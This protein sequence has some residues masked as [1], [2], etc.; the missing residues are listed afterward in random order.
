MPLDVSIISNMA[1]DDA[2]TNDDTSTVGEPS[3]AT[4]GAR[5]FVTGNWYA[6][7]S[8]DDGATWTWVDPVNT[9]P[10][11]AGGFCCDQLALYDSARAIWIWI[12]QYRQAGASNVFRIAVT[13]D[14]NFPAGGWYWW[15]IAPSTLDGTWGNLWFDYPDGALSA[16]TSISPS[17]CSTAAISGSGRW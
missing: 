13:R 16:G 17:T 9:T 3:V 12:I 11:A 15:D 1:L 7:R 4:N 6:S 2:A 10:G 8:G 14:A 5:V